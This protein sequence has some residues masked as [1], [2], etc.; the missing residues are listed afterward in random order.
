SC[1]ASIK[2]TQEK[3]KWMETRT[4][5]RVCA[6]EID[7]IFSLGEQYISNFVSP[8]QPDGL[9]VP[10]DLGLCRRCAL[11]QLRHSVSGEMMYQ[12]YWYRSGTNQTMR[13]ALAD[14]ANTAERL[15]NLRQGEA[16]LDIGCNDGTLLS[17]YETAG[18]YK[19]G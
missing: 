15:T 19:I 7:F 17:S 9:K 10:L 6:G 3:E 4:V 14:I 5:C 12:H 16:V 18:I 1:G 13:C 8:E 11:L 2:T